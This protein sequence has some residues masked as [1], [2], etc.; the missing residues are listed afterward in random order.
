[1]TALTGHTLVEMDFKNVCNVGGFSDWKE[2]GGP[3]GT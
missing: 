3:V 1:M 2:N